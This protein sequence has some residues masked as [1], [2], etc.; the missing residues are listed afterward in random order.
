[1]PRWKCLASYN[2]FLKC[3]HWIIWMLVCMDRLDDLEKMIHKNLLS[4]Y[5]GKSGTH[6]LIKKKTSWTAI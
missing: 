5:S 2:C 1:M 3:L 6:N 4:L